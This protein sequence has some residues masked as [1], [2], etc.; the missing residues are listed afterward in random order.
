[1]WENVKDKNWRKEKTT[2]GVKKEEEEEEK[3]W[4]RDEENKKRRHILA[5]TNS[6][7]PHRE[8]LCVLR[9]D[10]RNIGLHIPKFQFINSNKTN[11]PVV[12]TTE[13]SSTL[14]F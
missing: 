5:A 6:V 12:L 3:E 14:C 8:F 1:M 11:I 2:S 13:K 4:S 10:R 9:L 7:P